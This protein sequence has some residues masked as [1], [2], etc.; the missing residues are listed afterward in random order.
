MIDWVRVRELRDE[1]G[2]ADFGEVV[3]LFLEEADQV[4]SR[5][6]Q[7][8]RKRSVSD[9]LHFLKGA[10]LNLGFSDLANRCEEAERAIAK[11]EPTDVA[12][13]AAWFL[14]T[15]TEFMNGLEA[16]LE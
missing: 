15:R 8:G 9:D 14:E 5:I 7:V 6:G 4:I 2:D 13:I 10:A 16:A 12:M 3:V 1:I 11:G